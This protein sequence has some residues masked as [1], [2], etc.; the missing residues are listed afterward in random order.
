MDR[1]EEGQSRRSS[2]S[3][4]PAHNQNCLP[5]TER[6]VAEASSVDTVLVMGGDGDCAGHALQLPG[7]SRPVQEVP[8][9]QLMLRTTVDSGSEVVRYPY[10]TRWRMRRRGGDGACAR[11]CLAERRA[12]GVWRAGR[13]LVSGEPDAQ[14]EG[15]SPCTLKTLKGLEAGCA[16]SPGLAPGGAEGR[17]E[18]GA[19]FLAARGLWC[20]P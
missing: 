3:A 7:A 5:V 9:K 6:Q 4:S 19:P 1:V 11:F 13:R 16:E 15:A 20:M 12:W 2:C 17:E 8:C 18:P 10:A 14:P